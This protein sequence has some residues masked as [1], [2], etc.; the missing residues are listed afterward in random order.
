MR[1]VAAVLLAV[2]AAFP[3]WAG[4]KHNPNTR[5]LTI[6]GSTTLTQLIAASNIMTEHEVDTVYL[7][8]LGGN[9]YAGLKLGLRIRSEG[10]RVIIP[11]G[12]QC[13]SA[14]A[15]AALAAPELHIDGELML[16]RLYSLEVPSMAS[17]EEISAF[18]G[19]AYMDWAAYM[20]EIGFDIAVTKQI[21]E[22]TSP[23]KFMVIKGEDE[24][25]HAR[26]N[27][28]FGAYEAR[29]LCAKAF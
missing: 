24:V 17:I 19:A 11:S 23:C 27:G 14:C 8:G 16:H 1:T 7:Y 4:V 3:A 10:A 28:F 18:H 5:S 6:T 25:A 9:F 12:Q 22:N 20:L 2:F 26:E 21:L 13:V 15:N 29:N